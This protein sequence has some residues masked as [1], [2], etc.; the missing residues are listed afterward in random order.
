MKRMT[1]ITLLVVLCLTFTPSTNAQ[2]A[3]GR[4]T[5]LFNG[6]DLAGWKTHPKQP[7]Q[8]R[9]ENGA[10]VGSGNA[11]SHLFS[12]RGDFAGFHLRTEAKINA[13]GNSGVYFRSEYGL[14]L[15]NAYPA[16][17]E[18]QIYLGGG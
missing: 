1:L 16:G 14:S 9:V 6:K 8:W 13:K 5:A 4:W 17:Y 12:E 3:Y 2:P 7:G 11:V 10:I 18:A 15:R